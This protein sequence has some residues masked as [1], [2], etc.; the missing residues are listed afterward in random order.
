M[1]T[2]VTALFLLPIMIVVERAQRFRS[3]DAIEKEL[4]RASHGAAL[5]LLPPLIAVWLFGLGGTA[6]LIASFVRDPRANALPAVLLAAITIY[7]MARFYAGV[8]NCAGAQDKVRKQRAFLKLAFGAGLLVWLFRSAPPESAATGDIRIFA[9][10]VLALWCLVTG[11]VRFWLLTAGGGY[12]L[13][14]IERQLKQRNR[15]LRP[16]R[17]RRHFWWRR[18]Q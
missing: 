1:I 14:R 7:G 18:N 12:A 6:E 3:L 10:I 16:A 13:R 9:L 15:A 5:I 2:F 4:Q 11:I 17:R 8:G